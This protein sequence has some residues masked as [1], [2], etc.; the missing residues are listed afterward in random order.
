MEGLEPMLG[1]LHAWMLTCLHA[2]MLT[3]LHAYMLTCLH[4][5]MLT[6]LVVY[7]LTCL[8]AWLLG[9]L[10][11]WML[12]CLHAECRLIFLLMCLSGTLA[13]LT[14]STTWTCGIWRV[15]ATTSRACTRRR[16]T[17]PPTPTITTYVTTRG[18]RSCREKL[19]KRPPNTS[20]THSSR[21]HKMERVQPMRNSS[22]AAL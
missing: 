2:Y 16:M 14:D 19:G 20:R 4:A 1:C 5:Y 12:T 18:T 21:P 11:A 17:T 8:H 10:H 15:H 6:C 3:C 7:M 13:W 9:C 22:K